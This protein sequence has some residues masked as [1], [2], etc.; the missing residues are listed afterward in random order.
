MNKMNVLQPRS[1]S[2]K[3]SFSY[4]GAVLRNSL[5]LELWKAESHPIQTIGQRGYLSH[6]LIHGIHGKQLSFYDVR[7]QLS[8][9]DVRTV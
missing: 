7:T 8:F 3:N 1:N 9:Y 2:Y 5:P 6:S 4:S